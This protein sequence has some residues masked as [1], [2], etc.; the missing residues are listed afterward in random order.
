MT[1]TEPKKDGSGR[2]LKTFFTELRMPISVSAVS[3]WRSSVDRS[4][5]TTATNV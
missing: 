3:T 4:R 2:D 5:L 1:H